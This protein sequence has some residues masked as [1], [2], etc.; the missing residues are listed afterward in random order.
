MLDKKNAIDILDQMKSLID[1]DDR[2][3]AHIEADN[4]LLEIVR[5]CGYNDIADAYEEIDKWYA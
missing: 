3:M 5:A 2:E 1:S 4:L